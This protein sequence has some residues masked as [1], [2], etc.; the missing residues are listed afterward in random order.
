MERETI[1]KDRHTEPKKVNKK[2]NG[3]SEKFGVRKERK[4]SCIKRCM[5]RGR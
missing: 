3:G 2:E 5:E 1:E 4:R